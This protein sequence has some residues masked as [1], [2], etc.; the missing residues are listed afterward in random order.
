MR[1]TLQ[2]TFEIHPEATR[3]DDPTKVRQIGFKVTTVL[4]ADGGRK[5]YSP[6]QE[7][8]KLVQ[9][10]ADSHWVSERE[11]ANSDWYDGGLVSRGFERD[12]FGKKGDGGTWDSNENE[13][14]FWDEPGFLGTG[15]RH[16]TALRPNQR[17]GDYEIRFKW[18]V[19]DLSENGKRIIATGEYILKASPDD[20]NVITYTIPENFSR[21]VEV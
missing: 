8:Y 20:F 9:E 10:V 15:Q 14:I 6:L 17:L 19:S 4:K 13:T 11:N 12:Q 1:L 2:V 18:Y 5:F 21:A 3:V 16:G 7:R